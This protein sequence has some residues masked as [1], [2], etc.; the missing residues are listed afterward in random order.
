[1][2]GWRNK[3]D[4]EMKINKIKIIANDKSRNIIEL[5]IE[6]KQLT[7]KEIS[8]YSGITPT[9]LSKVLKNMSEVLDV[10]KD[11]AYRIYSIKPSFVEEYKSILAP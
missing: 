7:A 4:K 6:K 11:W 9:Y 3:G 1:L 2:F 10:K 8:E 5:L